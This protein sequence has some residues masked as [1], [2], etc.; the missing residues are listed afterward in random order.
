MAFVNEYVSE[1]D[2]EKYNLKE[3]WLNFRPGRKKEIPSYFRFSWTVDKERNV[4]FIPAY[5]GK[6]EFSDRVNCI[7]SWKGVLLDVTLQGVSGWLD[8]E[9]GRGEKQW[10]LINIKK[11][12]GFL[13]PDVDIISVLKEAL[14]AF[15][16]DGVTTPMKDLRISFVF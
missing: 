13:V 1:E 2:I 16:C 8:Y 10:G 3:I 5:S 14:L 4:F 11:P 12:K 7:F 15:G 6:E 9:N